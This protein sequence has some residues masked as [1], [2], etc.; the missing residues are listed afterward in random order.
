MSPEAIRYREFCRS[1][2]GDTSTVL[3]V[4]Q[5]R[6]RLTYYRYLSVT[7]SRVL[8]LRGLPSSVEVYIRSFLAYADENPVKRVDTPWIELPSSAIEDYSIRQPSPVVIRTLLPHM[9]EDLFEHQKDE[10]TRMA[11]ADLALSELLI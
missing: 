3:Q 5:L 11:L 10:L 6:G 4:I 2:A 7:D 9:T 8:W 1:S